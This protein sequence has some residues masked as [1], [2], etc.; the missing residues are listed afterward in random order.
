MVQLLLE[1]LE[2]GLVRRLRVVHYR[3][4]AEVVEMSRCDEPVAAVVARTGG[5]EDFG[6]GLRLGGRWV[7]F[8]DYWIGRFEMLVGYACTSWLIQ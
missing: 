5:D 8:V 1:A 7:H 3:A 4:V 6:F 2:D